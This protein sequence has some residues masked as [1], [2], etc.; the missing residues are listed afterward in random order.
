MQAL[1]AK[2]RH[3]FDD[4]GNRP[5]SLSYLTRYHLR[6]CNDRTELSFIQKIGTAQFGRRERTRRSYARSFVMAATRT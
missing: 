3:A 5:A 4:F 6:E 2:L 1:R